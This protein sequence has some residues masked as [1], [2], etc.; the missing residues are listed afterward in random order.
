MLPLQGIPFTNII[1]HLDAEEVLPVN[2]GLP[3][4]FHR[5]L[6]V[7]TLGDTLKNPVWRLA[8]P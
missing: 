3:P 2:P 8:D 5:K 1:C 7:L 4:S 6:Q